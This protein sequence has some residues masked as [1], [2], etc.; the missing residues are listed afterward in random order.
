VFQKEKVKHKPH[1]DIENIPTFLPIIP[2]SGRLRPLIR[3]EKREDG[4]NGQDKTKK[5][6]HESWPR[7]MDIIEFEAQRFH[8]HKD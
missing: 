6:G 8:H 3:E 1:E 7:V 4:K 5:K 2:K